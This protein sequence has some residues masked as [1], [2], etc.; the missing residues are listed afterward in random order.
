M[1]GIY[2]HIPYCKTR[3]IYCDFFT[4]TD[5]KEKSQYLLALCKELNIRKDYFDGELVE[6]VYF[7]GGTPSQLSLS[8]FKVVFDT[9]YNNH[10][11]SPQAEITIE[12]NP[13]DLNDAYVKG[14]LFHLP[15]NR[16]SIGIQSFID[17][18][19]IFLSRRHK[20]QKAIDA[21]KRCQDNG[22]DNISIDLMYGLPNQTIDMWDYNLNKALLLDVKHISAYHLIYEEGTK[23]YRM[24]EAGSINAVGEDTSLEMFSLLI[25]RL[26][27]GGFMHYEISNFAKEGY[28]SRHNS[29]Y[30]L[31]KKYLGIG[32]AAHSFDGKNRS[33]NVAS[34]DRYIHEIGQGRV[35]SEIEVLN[36]KTAYNDFILTGMRT[37][38]GVNLELLE[39]NFGADMLKYCLNNVQKHLE[40]GFVSKEDNILKLSRKGIFISDSIM[41]DLMYI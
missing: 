21:V 37:M 16:I 26:E 7:G 40:G 9:I 41:S 38:W 23:L 22:F 2:I 11:I 19:L 14:V 28:F 31:G 27:A 13:D 33:F 10:E 3:C 20:A 35:P 15:I 29:S 18:E 32:S 30:W 36:P 12:A 17:D 4:Q 1:A 34:I 5:M 25:D 24:F 8:D 39:K 6:T